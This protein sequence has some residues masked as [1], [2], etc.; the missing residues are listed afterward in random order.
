MREF[1][2]YR[3]NSSEEYRLKYLH[4]VDQNKKLTLVN[5]NQQKTINDLR[6][7]LADTEKKFAANQQHAQV[8][9][10]K[11]ET[12]TQKAKEF[13]LKSK[14]SEQ[15]ILQVTEECK[16]QEE[17]VEKMKILS[18]EML[19]EFEKAANNQIILDEKIKS[20]EVRVEVQAGDIKQKEMVNKKLSQ[21]VKHLMEISKAAEKK[22]D[23]DSKTIQELRVTVSKQQSTIMVY[24]DFKTR[25]QDREHKILLKLEALEMHQHGKSQSKC[26]ASFRGPSQSQWFVKS[27]SSLFENN[28]LSNVE[29]P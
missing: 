20:L 21:Q 13:E 19:G 27:I 24:E 2:D 14:D 7:Q 16:R 17:R 3:I 12:K 4:E 18:T 23:R 1:A 11:L 5:E 9:E 15:K 10:E 28:I 22:A 8:L 26:F 6:K 29:T 25:F